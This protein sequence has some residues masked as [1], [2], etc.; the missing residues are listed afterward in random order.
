MSNPQLYF[1]IG[2]PC[3]TILTSLVISLIG[4]FAIRGEITQ[5][6]TELAAIHEDLKHIVQALNDLDKRVTLLEE[7]TR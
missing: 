7:R 6:R 3:F 5:I 1:A 4:M 2:I